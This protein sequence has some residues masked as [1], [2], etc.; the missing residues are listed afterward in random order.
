MF[1]KSFNSHVNDYIPFSE[2]EMNLIF[3]LFSYKK[4]SKGDFLSKKGKVSSETFFILSGYTRTYYEDVK[5]QEHVLSF[6]IKNWW[7]G[8]F[9]SFIKQEPANYSVQCLKNTEVL[10]INRVALN[11]AFE[12]TPN[13][14]RFYRKLVERAYISLQ[15]RIVS[16]LSLTAKERYLCFSKRFPEIV[17]RVPQYMIASYLG[18]TKEFL[19]KIK[20]EEG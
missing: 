20:K 1:R 7:A 11:Q 19:S 5:G 10:S 18:I 15:E 4:Y 16:N 12:K 13:F 3:P 14:E 2:K 8:D 17:E 9:A 6:G